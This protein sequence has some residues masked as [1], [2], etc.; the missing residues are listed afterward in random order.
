MVDDTKA[1]YA[2]HPVADDSSNVMMQCLVSGGVTV[3]FIRGAKL[4]YCLVQCL[5]FL[6]YTRF[7]FF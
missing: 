5:G 2:V 3:A 7:R 1:E 4:L 6:R